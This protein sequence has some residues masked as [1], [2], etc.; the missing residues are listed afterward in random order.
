ME[1]GFERTKAAAYAWSHTAAPMLSGTL[2]TVIGFMPGRLRPID[3]RRICRQHLLDRRLRA[4]RLLVRR[5]GLHALSR[6]E[7]AARHQAGPGRP[8]RDLRHAQ[9]PAA[10]PRW[11]AGRSAA[12]SSSPAPWSPSFVIAGVGMGVG[13]E[14]VLPDLG[15]AGGA[16][17]GADA[18][19]H[20]HRG[21]Q[22]RHA[23][24]RGLAASS[25]RKPRSSP[26]Y[27]GQGA[28]RFFLS[29]NPELP[30]PSFA[31]IIV[32]TPDAE[33]RDALKLRLRAQIA[34]GLAPE[35]RLR[36]TQLVFGPYSR[37]PVAFRV[38]GP[39]TAKSC[40]ASPTRS[41]R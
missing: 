31:K 30:D 21:D 26:A 8:R 25:S 19:R 4:D 32:L 24:G 9:L 20:Q 18:G 22:R 5:G 36:A 7:D 16:G 41:R 37:F 1:E 27:I 23:Q 40:A 34:E 38:M 12:S 33:A 28:P 10:A 6:R 17:R 2:V 39:D 11:S 14:A 29:Y 13:Q 15:P 35:A 3:R